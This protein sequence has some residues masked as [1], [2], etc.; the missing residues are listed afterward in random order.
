[1]SVINLSENN[2]SGDLKPLSSLPGLTAFRASNNLLSGAFSFVVR[3]SQQGVRGAG[4]GHWNKG[5][6]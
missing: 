2:L 5:A 1:M 3:V 6:D 4:D